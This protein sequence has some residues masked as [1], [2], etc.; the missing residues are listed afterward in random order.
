M[1]TFR[2]TSGSLQVSGCTCLGQILV[3]VLKIYPLACGHF[4]DAEVRSWRGVRFEQDVEGHTHRN[5]YG[6][7]CKLP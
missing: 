3:M 7:H 5:K 6:E 2:K 4:Y 1:V